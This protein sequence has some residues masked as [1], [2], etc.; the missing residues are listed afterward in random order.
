MGLRKITWT[1]G[2]SPSEDRTNG[3]YGPAWSSNKES[4]L[5]LP[6]PIPFSSSSSSSPSSDFSYF[7][8]ESKWF[9]FLGVWGWF[10]SSVVWSSS[11]KSCWDRED[12]GGFL[13]FTDLVS[14]LYEVDEDCEND[15]LVQGLS[16]SL[17]VFRDMGIENLEILL[18][19]VSFFHFFQIEA[20]L[21]FPLVNVISIFFWQISHST[22]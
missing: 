6:N 17:K 2:F 12:F 11:R 14:K 1:R 16:V 21:L 4:N 18:A 9:C 15:W 3:S 13:G 20:L 7:F 5:G 8:F 10:W 22:K 19:T